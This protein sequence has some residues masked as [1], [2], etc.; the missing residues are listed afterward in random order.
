MESIR[1]LAGVSDGISIAG[2]TLDVTS[3]GEI[4]MAMASDGSSTANTVGME[5]NRKLGGVTDG[6]A[7]VASTV[8]VTKEFVGTSDGV[9]VVAAIAKIDK[10]FAG[11]SD[12]VATVIAILDASVPLAGLSTGLSTVTDVLLKANVP[13]RAPP[14][15]CSSTTTG[16]LDVTKKFVAVSDGL[17]AVVASMVANFALSGVADGLAPVQA[18]LKKHIV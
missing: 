14:V 10:T 9:A 3:G 15:V 4:N 17:A 7:A 1:K 5:A 12:G 2:A 16:A 8:N 6:I 11:A 18:T 13:I